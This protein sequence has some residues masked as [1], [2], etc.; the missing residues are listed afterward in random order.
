MQIVS[1]YNIARIEPHHNSTGDQRTKSMFLL[2]RFP[3][4][5][6]RD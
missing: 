5:K 1:E 6:L 4:N 3:L 2:L